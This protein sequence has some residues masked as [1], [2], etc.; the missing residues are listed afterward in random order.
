MECVLTA[1]GGYSEIP[2]LERFKTGRAI[3]RLSKKERYILKK[4][5]T[6]DFNNRLPK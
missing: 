5:K 2:T 6:E 4:C 3:M 1:G